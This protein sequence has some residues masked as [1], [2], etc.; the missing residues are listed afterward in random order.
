MNAD[1]RC[2]GVIVDESWVLTSGH[3]CMEEGVI[4][5]Q[6]LY[7]T[8]DLG[9]KVKRIDEF[10]VHS[11]YDFPN[12]DFCM[13][14]IDEPFDFANDIGVEPA[15]LPNADCTS[16][17]CF[18][19]DTVLSVGLSTSEQ[20]DSPL[21]TLVNSY[22]QVTEEANCVRVYGP[23]HQPEEGKYFCVAVPDLGLSGTCVGDSGSP[24]YCYKYGYFTVQ[25]LNS[26][27][28]RPDC[29]DHYPGYSDVC[30]V[31]G[32][33]DSLISNSAV[34]TTTEEVVEE[35]TVATTVQPTNAPTA[36][37]E[38][39]TTPP[40]PFVPALETESDSET[41]TVEPTSD[42]TEAALEESEPSGQIEAY[43]SFDS[44]TFDN[45]INSEYAVSI[46]GGYTFNSVNKARGQYSLYFFPNTQMDVSIPNSS[47]VSEWSEAS[48]CFFFK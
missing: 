2:G 17:R 9:S 10:H 39:E 22:F 23:E 40:P 32:W 16:D 31:R 35:T 1:Y 43:L 12:Y 33:I 44:R 11:Q 25:G 21:P 20:T 41:I 24:L 47:G 14:K 45:E 26:W 4:D 34:E 42:A 29:L 5:Y 8:N 36:A 6:I 38:S 7:A 46:N 3:C 27:I 18:P 37:A 28:D 13:L 48:F 15:C 30:Q 19:G